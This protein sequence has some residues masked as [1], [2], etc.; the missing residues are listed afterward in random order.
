MQGHILSLYSPSAPGM[1]SNQKV[2]TFVF[3]QA[4]MLHI[5]LKEIEL[6]AP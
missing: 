3:L 4:V 5:K 2:K 6:I 1:G